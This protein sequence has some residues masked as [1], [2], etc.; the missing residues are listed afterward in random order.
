MNELLRTPPQH[1]NTQSQESNK[2]GRSDSSV[3]SGESEDT[4]KKSRKLS[5][6]EKLNR[7]A[8]PSVSNKC[9]GDMPNNTT[10]GSTAAHSATEPTAETIPE[11]I[12]LVSLFN[13][14]TK[15]HVEAMTELRTN[16][17]KTDE[18][19]KKLESENLDQA[20]KIQK[21]QASINHFDLESRKRNVILSNLKEWTT[22]NTNGE[23]EKEINRIL[24][25]EMSLPPHI[26]IDT[27]ERIPRGVPRIG[28]ALP[29]PVKI[30]LCQESH[31]M[32][33]L[34]AK[35]ILVEN[36]IPLYINEDFPTDLRKERDLVR[37]M[38]K[39]ARMQGHNVKLMGNKIAIDG[40]V[41]KAKDGILVET[42]PRNGVPR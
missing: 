36:K 25:Q 38:G 42:T 35:K 28:S 14:I 39:E 11:S 27:A 5:F 16:F 6:R 37:I 31:R 26:Q 41:F 24:H 15:N 19:V 8:H 13:L 2:R 18:R 32:A 22:E 34:R 40:E 30:K 4:G 21:L 9:Q 3:A 12:S 33:V 17:S 1:Q 23:L 10:N 29:R 7:F 20:V